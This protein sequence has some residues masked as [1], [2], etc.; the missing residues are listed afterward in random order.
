MGWSKRFAV[1]RRAMLFAALCGQVLWAQR[2][3]DLTTPTPLPPGATLVVGFL[4]GYESWD[5]PHRGVRQLVLRL[6]AK[7]GV[8]AES[9][10]NHQRGVALS[11][12]RRALDTNRNGRLDADERARARVILFGQS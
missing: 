5:D 9:I 10:S 7:P 3:A 6:R 2:L 11:L 8:Y 1:R 4:G 12:I